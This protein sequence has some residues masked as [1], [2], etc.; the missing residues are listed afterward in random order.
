VLT[1]KVQYRFD[2]FLQPINDTAH[3]QLCGSPCPVSIFKGGSTIPVKFQIKDFNGNV[4]QTTGA[5]IWL[6]PEK[7][8]AMNLT[9]DEGTYLDQASSGINIPWDGSQYHYN[10]GTPKSGVGYYWRIG[11]QLD[12]GTT[13]YVYIGLK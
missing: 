3:S 4:V 12:D 2:G 11:V 7:G 6:T 10:W 9:I 1:Q 5:L 8:G 13:Q